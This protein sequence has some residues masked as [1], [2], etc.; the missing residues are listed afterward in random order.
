MA[1][2]VYFGLFAVSRTVFVKQGKNTPF[3]KLE[4]L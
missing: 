2:Q 4:N 1:A 3:Y